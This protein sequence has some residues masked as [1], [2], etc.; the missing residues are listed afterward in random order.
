MLDR[1]TATGVVASSAFVC[2]CG[3]SDFCN[4][5]CCVGVCA[6]VVSVVLFVLSCVG[7]SARVSV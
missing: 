1:I 2:L 4:F 6:R 3:G 5:C 7:V